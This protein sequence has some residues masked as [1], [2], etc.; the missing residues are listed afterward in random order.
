M[1]TIKNHQYRIV[2]QADQLMLAEKM[3][4][5][6]AVLLTEWVAKDNNDTMNWFTLYLSK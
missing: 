2:A 3:K 4:K 5:N 1:N 6:N